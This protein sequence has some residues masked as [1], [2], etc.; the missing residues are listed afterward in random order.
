MKTHFARFGVMLTSE[1]ELKVLIGTSNLLLTGGE[2]RGGFLLERT[3]AVRA[4]RE[5]RAR[6]H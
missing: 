6:Y 3:A 4:A 1:R 5:I 2:G